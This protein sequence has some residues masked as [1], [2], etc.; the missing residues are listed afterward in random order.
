MAEFGEFGPRSNATVIIG[1]CL[2]QQGTVSDPSI[3]IRQTLR[4]T[5]NQFPNSICNA[6]C[7]RCNIVT[8]MSRSLLF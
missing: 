3:L 2:V 8:V 6:T 7:I 5:A 4:A 1:S